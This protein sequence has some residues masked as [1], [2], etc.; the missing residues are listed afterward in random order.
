MILARLPK[1]A[2]FCCPV[3]D[4]RKPTYLP[5]NSTESASADDGFLDRV[6]GSLQVH[7]NSA[8]QSLVQVVLCRNIG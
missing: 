8:A 5:C 3:P 6:I 7:C 2:H 4:A 1:T